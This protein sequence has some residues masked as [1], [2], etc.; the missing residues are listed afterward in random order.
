MA[1]TSPASTVLDN[2]ARGDT[3]PENAALD[4]TVDAR[5]AWQAWRAARLAS[6]VAPTGNLSLIETRWFDDGQTGSETD[7]AAGQ[8]PTVTVSR[9]ERR[10]LATGAPE[11]GI[12]LWDADSA[13]IRHFDTITAWDYDPSWVIRA[14]FTPVAADR[15][16]PFEHIRDNGG[17]RDLVVPGD[18]TF[19]RG[20][21]EYTFSAFDDGGTLL[22]VFGDATNGKPGENGSYEAGRFLFV[23]REVSG[24]GASGSGEPS[25][26]FGEP[27]P[28]ILDFNRAFVPPCGFSIHYNCPLPPRNNRFPFPVEAGE[29]VVVF[30]GGHT[31]Y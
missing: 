3:A 26:G 4:N 29:K 18:I 10:N 21:E 5:D 31:L 2:T 12:R 23:H 30:Q 22:I 14:E 8:L 17:T 19:S 1:M 27:G 7:A 13:A 25:A 24:N 15:T 28:V 11:H 6:V 16:V 20:G 9:L